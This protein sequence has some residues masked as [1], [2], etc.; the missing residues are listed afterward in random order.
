M[1]VGE[2]THAIDEKNRLV[3]PA[4]FRA[5]ITDPEDK[6]GF[7]IVAS[8]IPGE[9]CLRLYTMSGWKQVAA[10]LREEANKAK[11]P[12][13]YLRFFASRGE[14]GALDSQNRLVVPQKLMDYAGLKK[15]IL[16][17]GNVDWIEVWNVGEYRAATESLDE[18][19]GDRNRA[20]WP[21]PESK[22]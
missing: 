1:F 10:K 8:P 20:M 7:F 5:F 17:V 9:H 15:E 6:K 22:A 18:E 13:R 2:F 21:N 11:D 4:K 14:F 3:L 16:M 12:A 19:I